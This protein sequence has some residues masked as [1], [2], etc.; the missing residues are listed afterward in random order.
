MEFK[1][2]VVGFCNDGTVHPL[3]QIYET[4]CR[5]GRRWRKFS[6]KQSQK[7]SVFQTGTWIAANNS[8][9]QRPVCYKIIYRNTDLDRFFACVRLL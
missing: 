8:H 4:A 5:Y 2:Y 9:P 6:N 3:L 1:S 7:T